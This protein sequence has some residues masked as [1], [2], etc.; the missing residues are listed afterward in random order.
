MEVEEIIRAALE[1]VSQELGGIN[2]AVR[3]L[4]AQLVV[5]TRRVDALAR[6]TYQVLRSLLHITPYPCISSQAFNSGRGS[7]REQN[8]LE[9]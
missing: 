1:P 7:G 4:A 3:K 2:H 5:L 8:F 9:K 6:I